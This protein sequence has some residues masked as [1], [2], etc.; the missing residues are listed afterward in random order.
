LL[1]GSERGLQNSNLKPI[2]YKPRAL[3][4]LL[5]DLNGAD[6]KFRDLCDGIKSRNGQPVGRT[7]SKMEFVK[8]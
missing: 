3:M 1:K 4:T 7:L 8:K 6:F 5:F 2:R